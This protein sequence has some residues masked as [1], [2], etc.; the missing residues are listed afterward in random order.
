MRSV[1][2]NSPFNASSSAAPTVNMSEEDEHDPTWVMDEDYEDDD[3]ENIEMEDCLLAEDA[4]ASDND[5]ECGRSGTQIQPWHDLGESRIVVHHNSTSSQ[6]P[7]HPEEM[8]K[9][10]PSVSIALVQERITHSYGFKVSY[11]KAWYAKQKAM[12]ML[13][14]DWEE[15]Y[16]YL[17]RQCCEAFNFCKPMIQ[18]DGTHLYKKYKGKLL[19]VMA[20]DGNNE[21]LP[22]AFAIVEGET[23]E[24]WSYSLANLRLHV[25]QA[26]NICLLSYRHASILSAVENNPAWLPPHVFHVYCIRH[27]ASNFNQ[28]FRNEKLK[29]A[30]MNIGYTPCMVD[31]ERALARFRDTSTQVV[32]WIDVIP[33][34][35]WSR[36]HDI[37]GRR[38]GHMTTNLSESINRVLKGARN[39]PITGLVKFTYSRLVQYCVERGQSASRQVLSG[40]T[41][42]KNVI[43]SLTHNESVETMHN[44]RTYNVDETVFEV[45]AGWEKSYSDNLTTRTCQCGQFKAFKYPYSHVVATTLYIR[46]VPVVIPDTNM[47]RAKGCPKSTIIRNEMDEVETIPSCRLCGLCKQNGHNRR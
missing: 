22:L 41:Y 1:T 40:H 12:T 39:M 33:K 35:K 34:E 19:I 26:Q 6:V 16:A 13:Y 23:L 11:R 25:T 37:E 32:D 14:G 38:Y 31:F 29:A 4:S 43:E 46:P 15:S 10:E 30:L 28:R 27:I 9:K 17:P 3:E 45:D 7:E 2:S 21:C 42:C 47:L 44:V 20:Q 24:A 5:E 36:A 18:I 8:I